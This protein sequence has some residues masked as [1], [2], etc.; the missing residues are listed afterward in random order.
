MN[1]NKVI[2]NGRLTK[3]IVLRHT[4]NNNA[5][6]TFTIASNRPQKTNGES[7]ADFIQCVAFKKN[8]ENMSKFLRKGSKV[9]VVGRL[10]TRTY[11]DSTGKKQYVTEVIVNEVEFLD[12]INSDSS[13]NNLR[14]QNNNS[15]NPNT[16]SEPFGGSTEYTEKMP[17]E[18]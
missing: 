2:L 3:E 11:D 17:W 7:E 5:V 12:P 1:I 13:N 6:C 4:D 16:Q 9:C 15:G 18:M 8:A 14:E 10:T